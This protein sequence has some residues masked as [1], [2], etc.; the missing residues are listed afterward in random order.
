[1]FG[2]LIESRAQRARRTGGSL[3]S[4][5]MHAA[6]LGGLVVV[7][8]NASKQQ[9]PDDRH[10]DELHFAK[11][12]PPPPPPISAPSPTQ[13][14]TNTP[15]AKG[16]QVLIPPIDIPSVIPPVD[17]NASATNVDDFTGIGAKNGRSTGVAGAAESVVP[18]NGVY[19]VLQVE[20]PVMPVPG[21]SGPAYPDA[22]RTAGID[23]V[24][25][26]QFVVDTTGR[27]DVSSFVALRSD[28]ELF[29]S[30][31]R[32]ALQRMRFMPAEASGRKV[33]QLVQQSF[34]FSVSKE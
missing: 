21:S 19:D 4:I 11:V 6:I 29:S 20:K 7:T 5:T 1:M 22:L 30:A 31:V 14:F 32:S 3:A 13:L 26:A 23:G 17:L 16:F 24:V 2:T 8:A 27:V 33:R 28:H 34:V 10:V 15:V 18:V 12:E 9:Q 25:L